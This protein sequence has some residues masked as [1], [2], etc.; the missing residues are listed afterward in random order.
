MVM[1][2]NEAQQISVPV[3]VTDLEAFRRWTDSDDFP[4][5]VRIWW[6]KGEVW[7][8]M[9]NEQIFTHVRVKTEITTVLHLLAKQ[10]QLGLYFTDGLLLSNF[11]A[12]IS[13]NPDGLF[14]STVTLASDRIRLIEGRDGGFT[15][16][17]GSPDMVLEIISKSS[18][19]KDDVVLRQAYWEADVS[20][21]WIVDVR[22]EAIRFD[23]LRCAK[24][25]YTTTRK[26]DGWVKSA[27]FG[28]SFRL[29][30]RAGL[31]GHPD[32]SLE[33]R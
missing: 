11:A 20:E 25:G 24:R 22:K 15:E 5:D 10:E 18:V 29:V 17:Q 33:M 14:L 8:D 7:I 9:S 13:G 32:Y 23:I 26:Q 27:V 16:L 1:V 30:L 2:V 28:K 12:D 3:Q 31:G 6:L 21:Y 19:N 4:D